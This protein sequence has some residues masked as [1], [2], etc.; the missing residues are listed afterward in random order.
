[1]ASTVP[2]PALPLAGA[3]QG[4]LEVEFGERAGAAAACWMERG[5]VLV[6]WRARAAAGRFRARL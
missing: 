2:L 6:A 3:L 5:R 1:M 4:W